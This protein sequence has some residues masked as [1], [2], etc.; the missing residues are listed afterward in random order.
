M[1]YM[2]AAIATLLLSLPN[3]F[4]WDDD[5]IA[6]DIPFQTKEV[7]FY[8]FADFTPQVAVRMEYARFDLTNIEEWMG[9]KDT[10]E[11]YEIDLV[12]TKYPK[13]ISKWRTDYYQ[14]LNDRL[15]TLFEHD[16]G[17]R[18]PNIK[19]NMVL[20]TQCITEDQAKRY[21]HGFVIKHRP[22]N[23]AIIRDIKS[24]EQLKTLISGGAVVRDST[25]MRV[26][27]RNPEWNNMLVVMDWT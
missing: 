19:W 12:F 23:R 24:P 10:H 16:P 13:E 8:T 7:P 26:L 15:R 9:L 6:F 5:R 4:A 21:F 27:E 14:L 1:K 2:F 3:A 11:A 17:L 22:R 20:Q 25:V 18:S